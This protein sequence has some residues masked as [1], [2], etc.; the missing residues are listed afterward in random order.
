MTTA[1]WAGGGAVPTAFAHPTGGNTVKATAYYG[2]GSVAVDW[3]PGTVS[4]DTTWAITSRCDYLEFTLVSGT[5]LNTI[6]GVA[7]N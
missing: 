5:D 3:P 2:D 1:M 4:V 7:G 6:V